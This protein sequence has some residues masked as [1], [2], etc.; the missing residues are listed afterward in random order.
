MAKL[1]ENKLA[2]ENIIEKMDDLSSVKDLRIFSLDILKNVIEVK[3]ICFIIEKSDNFVFVNSEKESLIINNDNLIKQLQD[4]VVNLQKTLTSD[5]KEIDIFIQ[6]EHILPLKLESNKKSL[7]YILI[8]FND[9]YDFEKYQIISEDIKIILKLI[10]IKIDNIIL[11]QA[12]EDISDSKNLKV[13]NTVIKKAISTIHISELLDFI[14]EYLVKQV[15]FDRVFAVI[16]NDRTNYFHGSIYDQNGLEKLQ[17]N[18][19]SDI[20]TINNYRLLTEKIKLEESIKNIT[21]EDTFTAFALII[22]GKTVGFIGVDNNLTQNSIKESEIYLLQSIATQISISTDNSILYEDMQLNA[23]GF[24]NL[25]EIASSFNLI[26]DYEQAARVVVDKIC[27]TINVSQGYLISFEVDNYSKVIASRDEK[28]YFLNSEIDLSDKMKFAIADKNIV[29]YSSDENSKEKCFDLKTAL[30]IPLYIKNRL[31]GILCIGEKNEKRLFSDYDLKLVETISNQAVVTLENAQLYNKL[32][33][34]VVER[35][36]ELID[37]NKALQNQKEKLEIL[38]QRLQSIISSIPDGIL[39]ISK[40]DQ[41]LGTNPAFMKMLKSVNSDIQLESLT[42]LSLNKLL[43]LISDKEDKN[44]ENFNTL[45][46][47]IVNPPEIMEENKDEEKSDSNSYNLILENGI[48]HYYK[49]LTAPIKV[50]NHQKLKQSGDKISQVVVFHD[51]TK[52]K[53]IDKMK[54]DFI[55]VVSHELKTP[56]SAMMGFAT[57]IED[58]IAGD[59]TPEQQEYLYK[60]QMQGERLIRLIND[61]LDFSKLEAGQMPL[62]LQLLDS[63]DVVNEIVETLRPLSDEKTMTLRSNV[64]KDLPPIYVDP[65]KLKQILINLIS[66]A[67]KFTPEVTGLIEVTVIFNDQKQELLFS[68]SDNGIGIPEKDKPRLFDRFYQ[69]DNTSTRKYGGTGL[70]LAIVKKLV[71][72]NHGELWVD[73]KIGK[74]STFY[75]TV[76]LPEKE[77]IDNII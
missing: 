60:I 31:T 3:D 33:D 42:G 58:G 76:P 64:A 52:E 44:K 67:I 56:V 6:N 59:I 37:S 43:N 7:G 10:S 75:F 35:T 8:I 38:S 34:I 66:N 69:V 45:L 63:D 50:E 51:V 57:L 27:S 71:D 47:N 13:I 11:S 23:I 21:S 24:K 16:N 15:N 70:G 39:V 48:T 41:I 25:F 55:A 17:I 22:R 5:N 74:G 20:S 14:C 46:N 9:N 77:I 62:Y 26:I 28:S 29:F 65:D 54:S 18:E 19:L 73:T 4:S 1:L 2:L 72:L 53:E 49:V 68:V 40:E 12:N 61:L 30:I 32:E 36:V